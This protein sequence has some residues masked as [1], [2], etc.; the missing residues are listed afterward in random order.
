MLARPAWPVLALAGLGVASAGAVE[1]HEFSRPCR[2]EDLIG[3]WRVLRLGVPP[4]SPIDR[5]DPAFL[6]HQRYVFHSNATM[7]HVTQEVP[8]SAEAQRGLDK[9][10]ASDTW[11][12]E[13]EGRLVRQREGVAA[14]EHVD[15]RVMTR[16]VK[17]PKTSQLT[18]QAGDVLLTD[19]SVDER[20]ATRRLLRRIGRAR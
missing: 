1:P 20:T 14:V 6:P 18:A 7:A 12:L 8:F 19:R 5:S 17:D 4:G 3:V 11:T 16:A 15:C 2:Q 13:S 10:P 9:L